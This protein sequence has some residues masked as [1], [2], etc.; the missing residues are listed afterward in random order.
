MDMTSQ[1]WE[2]SSVESEDLNFGLP[3]PAVSRLSCTARGFVLPTRKNPLK[4]KAQAP[5][6]LLRRL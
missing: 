4:L 2:V 1:A 6:E 3:S 5:T